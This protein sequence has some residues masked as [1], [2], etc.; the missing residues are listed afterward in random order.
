MIPLERQDRQLWDRALI[1]EAT[2]LLERALNRH[3]PGVYQLQAAISAIHSEAASHNETRW[4]EI[5]LLYD[6]LHAMSTN[7]VYLLNRAV[8]LSYAESPQTALDA[9]TTI[10]LPLSEYQ[11]FYAAQADFLRRLGRKVE[12]NLAYNRAIALSNNDSEREFLALRIAL[13]SA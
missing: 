9:L 3:R 8:A 13:P 1:T 6:G 4:H 2:E 5:V 10:A 12:S 11:P 7:P